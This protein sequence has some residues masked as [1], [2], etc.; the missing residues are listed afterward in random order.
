MKK[1]I[2]L[3]LVALFVCGALAACGGSGTSSGGSGGEKFKAGFIFL[4]ELYL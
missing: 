1:I 2:A 4:Q 3:L